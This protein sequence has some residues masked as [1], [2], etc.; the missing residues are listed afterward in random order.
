MFRR[1]ALLSPVSVK[2]HF[3][4]QLRPYTLVVLLVVTLDKKALQLPNM[5]RSL[6]AFF[7]SDVGQLQLA[8]DRRRPTVTFNWNDALVHYIPAALRLPI[9][10]R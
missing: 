9:Y 10:F 3:L 7:F 4:P 2:H 6:C 1:S 8:R 5:M